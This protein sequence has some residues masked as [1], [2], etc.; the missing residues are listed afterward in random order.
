MSLE[1]EHIAPIRIKKHW[2]KLVWFYLLVLLANVFLASV[3]L[4]PFSPNQT[5][6]NHLYQPPFAFEFYQAGQPFHWLGTDGLGR[7]VLANLIF[8]ART[9]VLVSIPVMGL[10]TLL[11]VWAGSTAAYFGN[12]QL[13]MRYSSAGLYFLAVLGLF[14]YGFYLRKPFWHQ[15]FTTTDVLAETALLSGIMLLTGFLVWLI[16]KM[17]PKPAKSKGV[18]YVPLDFFITR[19]IALVNSV[20]KLILILSLAAFAGASFWGLLVLAVLTYWTAPARL[21]RAEALKV[22]ALPYIEAA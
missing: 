2:E 11:G 22:K 20:P 15:L 18:F 5:D 9:A 1:Q 12:R 4:L 16:K 19:F 8:G 13:T 3:W 21:V 17:L 10:A 6:L 7:D 14:F